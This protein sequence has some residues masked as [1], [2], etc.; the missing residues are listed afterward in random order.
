MEADARDLLSVHE[1]VNSATRD[2][3]IWEGEAKKG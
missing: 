3:S 1:A 2:A